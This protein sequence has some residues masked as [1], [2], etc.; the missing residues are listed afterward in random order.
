MSNQTLELAKDLI[1]IKSTPDNSQA[2]DQTL[3]LVLSNLEGFTIER[4]ER[5]NYKSALVYAGSKR[6]ENFKIILNGHLNIIPG[7]ENQYEPKVIGDRLYGVGSMDMKANV[8]CLLDVFKKTA[9][10]INYPIALQLV[11]DEEVGGFY[12]TKHQI[13]Q[14]VKADFVIA[15]EATAFN[16]VNQAKGVLW[17][18]VSAVGESAHAAYPW[19][20]DNAV[21]KINSFINRLEKLIPNPLSQEW[22]STVNLSGVN[23]RDTAFN[24]VPDYCELVLDIRFVPKDSSSIES[25]LKGLISEGMKLDILTKEPAMNVNSQNSFLVNLKQITESVLDKEVNFYGAQ[26]SSDARHYVNA[27]SIGVE[28][29]PIGGGI[30][31][32]E[33]WVDIPSLETYKSI[34]EKFVLSY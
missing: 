19:K 31:T 15:A 14:G 2:L 5:E 16:I 10:K 26:G 8:A 18:K 6:P 1:R 17:A 21:S 7:K 23:T 27:G 28:F 11:T 13:E 30:G 12:G 25:N 3:E 9:R 32:D 33:E 4:F 24:K 29:G 22:L 20:G 34:L